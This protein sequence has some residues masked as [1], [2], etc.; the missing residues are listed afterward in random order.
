VPVAAGTFYAFFG[1]VLSPTIACA[2]MS[3][4]LVSVIANTLRPRRLR[5]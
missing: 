2:A 4:N 1:W 3:F 5:L